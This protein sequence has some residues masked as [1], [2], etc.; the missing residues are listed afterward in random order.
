MN[1]FI[2]ENTTKT[3]FGKG[4]VKEYLTCLSRQYGRTVLF[5]YGEGSIKKNSIYDEI[6]ESLGKAGKN[7]IE[8]PGITSNP[9]YTKVLEGAKLA[10]ENKVDLIIAAGDGSV[11]DCCKAVSMA[12]VYEG[13]LWDDFIARHG[14]LEFNPIPLG[15]IVTTSGT[16]S[17]MNGRTVITNE[18]LKLRI[19]QDYPECSPKFALMDPVYTY[20]ESKRQMVS[21]GFDTLSRL[22]EN[23]F[24]KPDENN[25]SDDISEALMRSTISNLRDAVANPQ[26]YTARSNLMWEAAMA[27]NCIMK[28]G[29]QADI[30]CR[31][32]EYQLS[33]YTNCNDG[34][35]IAVLQPVYFRHI[36]RDGIAKFKR[37]AMNVW[38]IS[39]TGRTDEE[40]ACAG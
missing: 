40:T 28:L 39:D 16:G 6:M 35:G 3:Y 14:I 2:F 36:Y 19:G 17:G 33:A 25:V 15:V 23:Y 21:G 18:A 22:M 30:Q 7:V 11:M 8:F 12:A 27:G 34:E 37:F 31:Q 4:C 9:T 10:R 32:M 1:N 29:K 13:D 26:D 24:T 38:G 5:A 20:S